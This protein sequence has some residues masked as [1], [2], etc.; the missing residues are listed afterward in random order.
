MERLNIVLYFLNYTVIIISTILAVKVL[1][2][3]KKS[4]FELSVYTKKSHLIGIKLSK[5]KL[6]ASF[7]PQKIATVR[8]YHCKIPQGSNPS[9][10]A[11]T[12]LNMAPTRSAR[13][14]QKTALIIVKLLVITNIENAE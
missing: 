3:L 2:N 1:S 4:S 10:M 5:Q 14:I 8:L 11:K 13:I 6:I 9:L 12:I 7:T